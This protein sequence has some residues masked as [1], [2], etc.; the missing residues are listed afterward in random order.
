MALERERDRDRESS[1]FGRGRGGFF[2]FGALRARGRVAPGAAPAGAPAP[3]APPAPAH[4]YAYAPAPA[5]A[6]PSV[7]A[8][9]MASQA[10]D[11]AQ[12]NR[13][14]MQSLMRGSKVG[15]GNVFTPTG[16][17]AS[18]PATSYVASTSTSSPSD[19]GA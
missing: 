5:P 14:V 8:V 17:Y 4:A 12:T 16:E 3:P 10:V 11:Q 2:G 19:L 13:I 1:A 15:P 6:P 7:Q 18:K 9:S